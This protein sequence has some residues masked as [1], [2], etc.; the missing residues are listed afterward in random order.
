MLEAQKGEGQGK[1][2]HQRPQQFPPDQ[3]PEQEADQAQGRVKPKG[4][5]RDDQWWSSSLE[6]RT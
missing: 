1:G 4:G 5:W 6:Q 3:D 2:H